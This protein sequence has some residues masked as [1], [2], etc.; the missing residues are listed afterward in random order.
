LI[1]S[2][3]RSPSSDRRSVTWR[4]EGTLWTSRVTWPVTDE[5]SLKAGNS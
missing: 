5:K 2:P 4:S 1:S 3:W